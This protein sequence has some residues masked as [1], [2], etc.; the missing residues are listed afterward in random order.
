M[1]ESAFFTD[2]L[3][4]V[5]RE[6]VSASELEDY[7]IY[8]VTFLQGMAVDNENKN[9]EAEFFK[10]E[11]EKR[12]IPEALDSARKIVRKAIEYAVERNKSV[13]TVEDIQTAYV[14]FHGQSWPFSMDT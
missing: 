4:A 14:S 2:L 6:E 8:I 3:N 11:G 13:L 7:P 12:G 10:I 9:S 1:F 5:V